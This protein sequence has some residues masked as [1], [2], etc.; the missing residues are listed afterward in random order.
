MNLHELVLGEEVNSKPYLSSLSSVFIGTQ[1]VQFRLEI[2]MVVKG[3]HLLDR[4]FHL[5][6]DINDLDR[7]YP[8]PTFSSASPC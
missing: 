5:H 7:S 4:M 6:M 1:A 8:I 3:E 2:C